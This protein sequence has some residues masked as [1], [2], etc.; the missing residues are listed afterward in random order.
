MVHYIGYIMLIVPG[1]QE[2]ARTLNALICTLKD[3]RQILR[4]FRGLAHQ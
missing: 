1:E 2:E 4:D 3:G